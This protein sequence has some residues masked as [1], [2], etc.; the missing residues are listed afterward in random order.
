MRSRI[1]KQ[2]F[3]LVELLVV[4]AIIGILVALLL[5]A[6]QAARE[7][8]RRSQCTNHLK[9]LAL[10]ALN[11]ES[12]LKFLP[13]GGWG[14]LWTGD[15]N[16]GYG[17]KQPGGWT[18]SLLNFIEEGAVSSIGAGLPEVQKRALLLQQK[19]TPISVFHCPSRGVS[20][21]PGPEYTLNSEDVPGG[22]VAKT[23]YAANG[24][25]GVPWNTT[26][27]LQGLPANPRVGM[28]AGPGNIFCLKAYPDATIC[29]GLWDQRAASAYDG[30]FAPRFG[31]PLRKMIDG[32]SKTLMLSE[33]YVFIEGDGPGAEHASNNNSMYQG[34]DHDTVRFA[35]SHVT[36]GG[37]ALA[38]PRPVTEKPHPADNIW[39]RFG[40]A[41]PGVF[42]AAFCDGSVQSLTYE[43][44]PGEWER[45]GA[46]NDQ[47]G[48]CQGAA[49]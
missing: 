38:L 5:P 47:G 40:G 21:G 2:G 34:F 24:G 18:F 10:G 9:Q 25:C 37:N 8:A 27:N 23:D 46:R 14:H 26:L 33:R 35:S 29:S 45:F 13:S 20:L 49:P 17:A 7:S 19:I 31:V 15:P 39:Y 1:S 41:H 16:M 28:P 32:T 12:T 42:M 4:I 22:L 6:I 44:D 3:T 48:R 11:H 30:A 36:S 43:I